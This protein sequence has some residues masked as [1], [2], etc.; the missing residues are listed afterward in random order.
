MSWLPATDDSTATNTLKYEIHASHNKLFPIT[1]Q[2]LQ[3][4]ITG[5][6]SATLTGLEPGVSYYVKVTAKD[7][8]DNTSISNELEGR[9]IKTVPKRT[10]TVV[11]SLTPTQA[12]Q[13]KQGNN[14]TLQRSQSIQKGDFIVSDQDGG[15]LKKVK[16]VLATRGGDAS[17]ETEPA[18]LNQVFEDIALS[19]TIK[20]HDLPE[21]AAANSN[22]RG[23]AS[24]RLS[25][26]L[27]SVSWENSN[28]TLVS[29]E[30][31]KASTTPVTANRL[32]VDGNKQADEGDYF[33]LAG[34]AYKFYLPGESPDEHIVVEAEVFKNIENELGE[35]TG[36]TELCNI[37][38][39]GFDHPDPILGE[40]TP[41]LANFS[42]VQNEQGKYWNGELTLTW[43]P[44]QANIDE[45]GRPYIATI[46]AYVDEVGDNCNGGDWLGSWVDKLDL[47][48]PIYLENGSS[49]N[50]TTEEEIVFDEDSIENGIDI[51]AGIEGD[52]VIADRVTYDIQP[53]F[54]VDALIS[55]G[56]L[57]TAKLKAKADLSITNSITITS[58]GEGWIE[59][60]LN[61]VPEK[62]FVKVFTI[63]GPLGPIPVVVGGSFRLDAKLE[64]RV[65]GQAELEKLFKIQLDNSEFGLEYDAS[66]GGWRT[67]TN[68]NPDYT[69]HI[70]GEADAQ[71][72]LKLSFVPD[73]QVH[74]Y[75]AATGRMLVEPYLFADAEVHGQF[76]YLDENGAELTDLDYWFEKLESGAGL[77]LKLY[78]GLSIL[79]Y[80]IASYPENVD[81][82]DVHLYK[83]VEVIK[84]TPFYSLPTL[85]A[86]QNPIRTYPD[87]RTL[88]IEG[89]AQDYEFNLSTFTFGLIDKPLSLNPFSTWTPATLLS[90]QQNATLE[91]ASADDYSS[92]LFT[93]TEPGSYEIRMAGHSEAGHYVRQI[94]PLEI[95][96]T[97]ND[98]DGMVDQWEEKYGVDDPNA[99]EDGDGLN[100]LAEF[101][102][103]G[104]P[105]DNPFIVTINF[106]A[107]V[108]YF[109]SENI[110]NLPV[111]V[112][113]VIQG[114]YTFDSTMFDDS[115]S[116]TYGYYLFGSPYGMEVSV[117]NIEFKTLYRY[118][119]G[120][121]FRI[122]VINDHPSGGDILTI[123]SF[124]NS[125]TNYVPPAPGNY[126]MSLQFQDM[127]LSALDNDELRNA[128]S[129]NLGQWEKM[130]LVITYNDNGNSYQEHSFNIRASVTNIFNP[131]D[132]DTDGIIDSND[133]CPAVV[134]ED[135]QDT[136]NDGIG[137]A[138]DTTPTGDSDNDNVDNTTDNCPNYPNTNQ[139]DN[140]ADGVGN[141][142]DPTPNGDA[143]N[144]GAD[145]LDDNCPTTPNVNQSDK[146]SDGLGDV[147]DPTPN[148]DN[149]NDG[150]DNLADNCPELANPNQANF[151]GDTKGDACDIDD[152]NDGMSDTYELANGLDPFNPDDASLDPDNDGLNNLEEF[153]NNTD[154]NNADTDNDGVNDGTEVTIGLN[155][156]DPKDANG[157][158]SNGVIQ[159]INYLL[160]SE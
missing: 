104:F 154:P 139:A 82:D 80:N 28:L 7:G 63:P 94:A 21:S 87:S 117:K 49:G 43:Y 54:E 57:Q 8:D 93:Y 74:F 56:T 38:L 84:K 12:Y 77:D 36:E 149:D 41:P 122:D 27:V 32:V 115:D 89:N 109:S 51:N 160:L 95:I 101:Q 142:C 33:T 2:T 126:W 110:L 11:H 45:E 30:I 106:E 105:K 24:K 14:I 31:S 18:S 133:N 37:E 69:F 113:D 151:D 130:D 159:V 75:D 143:D 3:K 91:P 124:W 79:D 62:S 107:L 46:R 141:S 140:D 125:A 67:V 114:A 97:D 85:T 9:V 132:S 134:N 44:Q 147:C 17:L 103:G 137:D 1:A 153:N 102:Q 19:S 78:A 52:I 53:T 127:A 83:K 129:P 131:I 152:D 73:M 99:D 23:F 108:S 138:C 25:E 144:D 119:N 116:D 68:F 150:I 70:A 42:R 88:L 81:Y 66:N 146:D 118:I 155:P 72:N 121:D 48:I 26:G 90:L 112:G 92:Y 59:G 5:E 123:T 58:S 136:D 39:A 50:T 20:L 98:Q 40:L 55:D 100:N 148:G 111:Q 15:S 64:A 34:P 156:N 71:A 4:Q 76:K 10:R 22:A 86:S 158:Q 61:V 47:E 65:S 135:Q 120:G 29:S 128:A 157:N 145:N 6:S 96:L 13:A 60:S 35:I 16:S